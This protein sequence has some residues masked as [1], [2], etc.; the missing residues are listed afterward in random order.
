M[1][2]INVPIP[3]HA[4]HSIFRSVAYPPFK[5]P[6]RNIISAA[7]ST[8]PFYSYFSCLLTQFIYLVRHREVPTG[9]LLHVTET[10]CTMYL[11]VQIRTT[12]NQII[13]II[14]Y[15]QYQSK[16]AF[17][18]VIVNLFIT[19]RKFGLSLSRF[20]DSCKMIQVVY[21]VHNIV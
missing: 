6:N 15:Y 21:R 3:T 10:E 17:I 14:V 4:E 16:V 2:S 19:E 18:A 9:I 11:R 8:G 13:S 5:R 20:A 7:T 12:C 1:K